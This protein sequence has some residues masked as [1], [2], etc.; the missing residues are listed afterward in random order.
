MAR[1]FYK[2]NHDSYFNVN[3]EKINKSWIEFFDV[4]QML[5]AS[6]EYLLKFKT[7]ELE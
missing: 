7:I 2:K 4:F 1:D 6:K 5:K 3:K